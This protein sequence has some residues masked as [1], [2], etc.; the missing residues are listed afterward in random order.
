MGIW[1]DKKRSFLRRI[2]RLNTRCSFSS[3]LCLCVVMACAGGLLP[4]RAEAMGM[5]LGASAGG[6]LAGSVPRFSLSPYL[7]ISMP[8]GGDSFSVG[9]NE[10]ASLL[11]G[12]GNGSLGFYNHFTAFGAAIWKDVKVLAGPTLSFFMM[13]ACGV[14]W[15]SNLRGFGA[16]GSMRVDLFQRPLGVSLGCNIDVPLKS[17][18]LLP[19]SPALMFFAG[20]VFRLL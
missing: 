13:P 1:R 11:V 20:G 14:S 18:T 17:T 8:V 2:V 16:G 9:L 7:T 4:A 5:D 6:F 10:M 19:Q 3:K 15:C 12:A